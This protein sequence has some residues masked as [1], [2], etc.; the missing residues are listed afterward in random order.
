MDS[1]PVVRRRV[2]FVGIGVIALSAIAYQILLTRIFSVML[3]YHFAF[4]GISLAMLGLTIGAQHVYL[5]KDKFSSARMEMEWVKAAIGFAVSIV[6]LTVAFLYAP[7]ASHSAAIFVYVFVVPFAYSGIC[8]TLILTKSDA[9]IGR[10]YAADLAG[11]SLGCIGIVAILF[12]LDPVTI[13]FGLAFLIAAAAWLMARLS[14]QLLDVSRNLTV[15]LLVL[16]TLHGGL[17]LANEPH[18][19]V[20]WAKGT[21][22]EKALFERWNTFSLVRVTPWS[23]IP[24][25]WGFA[26]KHTGPGPE[27]LFLVID[28]QAGTVITK[29]DGKNLEALSY[30]AD[31]V[32][33][34]GYDLR[35]ADDAAI[36]GV[37]GGRDILSALYFGTKHIVGIELNPSIF[38]VLTKQFADFS[39]HLDRRPEVSLVNAEARSWINQ[40]NRSFDIIQISL[41]DTWAATAAGGLS[42]SENKLYTVDAW[43]DFLD[44]LKPD[45]ILSVSRWF[46]PTKHRGEFYRLLS[47]AAEALKQRGIS[48]ADIKQHVLVFGVY[49]H[50]SQ[51]PTVG[52]ATIVVTP[53]ALTAAELAN[54]HKMA[55]EHGFSLMVAPD[56]N[57]DDISRTIISGKADAKFYGSLPLDLSAPTDDRPFFFQMV[58][59]KDMILNGGKDTD[60][61]SLTG[62]NN[63]AVRLVFFLLIMTLISTFY[64]TFVP[65]LDTWKDLKDKR[66]VVPFLLYF[67]A[68][69]LGFMLIEISQ[70]Q[71][72]MIF[73]GH[74]VY[75]LTVVLF[76]LLLFGGIGSAALG[77]LIKKTGFP[78]WLVPAGLCAV[79]GIIGA[80]TPFLTEQF[81]IYST[82]LRVLV[83]I[84]LLA[85]AGFFMGMMFPLGMSVSSHYRDL[86]P[87]FWSINGA[88]SV[89]GSV[90]AVVISMDSGGIADAFWTGVACYV[91]CVLLICYPANRLDDSAAPGVD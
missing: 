40:S 7:L 14:G 80:A 13:I 4:V 83:S 76:T 36:I 68:I 55:E 23:N 70:M 69:G 59:M 71:R 39:G 77:H 19:R 26:H 15:A 6:V 65:M 82:V 11:A 8:V 12:F 75:G 90:L 9:P 72:L 52:I 24:F 29:F 41:I 25:A 50:S 32:I 35:P 44:H 84:A 58:R 42:L 46:D 86:Q 91:L 53:S 47:I 66:G 18:F 88:T 78:R 57:W 81:K 63:L 48:D 20:V 37:G 62:E 51:N 31:D 2:H 49:D 16:F 64:F 73:L 5:H 33:N 21:N 43:K 54:A 61:I 28:S 85:P 3:Y 79:L 67:G 38:E 87:W 74:P 34:V 27:Q 56:E 17:Y 45:G 22:L 30:L 10:L 60:D 1:Q 89:F